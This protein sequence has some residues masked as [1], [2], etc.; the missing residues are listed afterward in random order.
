MS[1]DPVQAGQAVADVAAL[2]VAGGLG[3]AIG[4]VT[5]LAKLVTKALEAERPKVVEAM[6]AELKH[7]V[8]EETA[9][10][11]EEVAQL[12]ERVAFMEGFLGLTVTQ[13]GPTATTLTL[14][15]KEGTHEP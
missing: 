13:S 8:Q 6:R 14:P 10:L 12:R 5:G 7:L 9:Q 11:R 3:G 2:L 15:R 4:A 1:L